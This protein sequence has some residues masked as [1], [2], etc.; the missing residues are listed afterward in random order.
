MQNATTFEAAYRRYPFAPFVELGLKLA[1]R[2]ARC[3][4]H[5]SAVQVGRTA[6]QH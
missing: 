2:L 3:R 1:A 5:G 6:L 4:K